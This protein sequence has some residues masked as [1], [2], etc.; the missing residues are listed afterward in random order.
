MKFTGTPFATTALVFSAVRAQNSAAVVNMCDFPVYVWSVGD[1]QSPMV[2]L[3]NSTVG[4]Q[5]PYH[6]KP[7]GSGVSIKIAPSFVNDGNINMNENITQFEYTL[8]NGS[9]KVWY[10]ISYVNGN[11][12]QGTHVVL[13]PSDT[14]CPNVTC[15]ATDSVCQA[16]YNNPND[17]LAT[18]ACSSD[19]D[20]FFLLCPQNA[21]NSSNSGSSASSSSQ[22]TGSS[23]NGVEDLVVGAN[24][25][26]ELSTASQ[27]TSSD[28]T[29]ALDKLTNFDA[30]S[31]T[32][33]H[34]VTYNTP[35]KRDEE[36][37]VPR[38]GH[39]HFHEHARRSRLF[40]HSHE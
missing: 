37:I 12:F 22:S 40:R 28:V 16:A 24:G 25:N 11:A 30:L 39:K 19:A 7:D 5:E 20:L 26:A 10:D 15:A 23:E 33:S 29:N 8:D 38:H 2:A 36:E 3:P 9:G 18:H 4:Y 32:V 27:T 1:S 35:L 13:Q 21:G 17:N 14:S 34:W 6:N 31:K